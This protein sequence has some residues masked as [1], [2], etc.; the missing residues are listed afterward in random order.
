MK[1]SINLELTSLDQVRALEAALALFVD[2]EGDRLQDAN[3]SKDA[4]EAAADLKILAAARQV[5]VAVTGSK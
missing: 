4:I 3:N 2:M 1:I 5:R